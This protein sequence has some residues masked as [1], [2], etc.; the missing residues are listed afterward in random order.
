MES[1]YAD[2]EQGLGKLSAE[3]ATLITMHG[4]ARIGEITQR[5]RIVLLHSDTPEGELCAEVNKAAMES[6]ILVDGEAKKEPWNV[7]DP[8]RING[9]NGV[10]PTDFANTGLKDFQDRTERLL[11]DFDGDKFLSVT[12]GYKGLIPFATLLVYKKEI[13]LVYL[14]ERSD[15]L[16]IMDKSYFQS[17]FGPPRIR[18][19]QLS[20]IKIRRGNRGMY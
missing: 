6:E 18:N 1:Y 11:D 12:G 13:T 2:E 10:K 4:E 7:G 5:D 14:F 16:V 3:M 20:G 9:L 8:V 17:R 19:D 15:G